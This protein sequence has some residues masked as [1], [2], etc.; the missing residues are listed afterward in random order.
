MV[1][2]LWCLSWCRRRSVL[3]GLISIMDIEKTNK[4]HTYVSY[5]NFDEIVKTSEIKPCPFCGKRKISVVKE[6]L[7]ESFECTISVIYARCFN[8]GAE[9]RH[10]TINSIYVS[11]DIIIK[12]GIIQW[13]N[14]Y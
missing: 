3:G 10:H 1:C 8:C 13:N 6:V 7:D 11:D 4:T 9:G 5:T 12:T 2:S 14:R